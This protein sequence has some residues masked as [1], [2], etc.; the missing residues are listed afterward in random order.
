MRLAQA[1]ACGFGATPENLIARGAKLAKENHGF[2]H[3]LVR[4]RGLPALE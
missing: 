3:F 4:R 2:F 1:K